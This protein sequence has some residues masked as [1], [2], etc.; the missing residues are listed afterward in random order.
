MY[1]ERSKILQYQSNP[2]ESMMVE[3]INLM[4][5]ELQKCGAIKFRN[6]KN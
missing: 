3:K 5:K 4:V 1:V 2:R 6:N